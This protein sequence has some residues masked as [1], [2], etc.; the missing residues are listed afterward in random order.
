METKINEFLE[1]IH[2]KVIKNRKYYTFGY[3][4]EYHKKANYDYGYI[5][6]VTGLDFFEKE[7]IIPKTNPCNRCGVLK[8]YTEFIVVHDTASGAPSANG[9]AHANWINSMANDVNSK[10]TVSWHFTVDEDGIYQHLPI[11]EVG[12]HAGDG[13]SVKLTYTDTL[14]KADK[15]ECI[16]SIDEDGFFVLNGIKSSIEAPKTV[17]NEVVKNNQLPYQGINVKIGNNGTYLLGNTYWNNSYEVLANKGGNLNSVGIETCVNYGAD[18]IKTMR[19]TAYLVAKLL[20]N[21]NLDI[22][23]V[24]QHNFFSGKDCP[25]TIRHANM[26]EEF[27]ELVKIN[28]IYLKEF[29]DYKIVFE[30]LSPENLDNEG[31]IIKHQD[32]L[33]VRYK[34]IFSKDNYKKEY[35]FESKLDKLS[36]EIE[37]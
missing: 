23:Q 11:D 7:E 26:W 16:V 28:L 34:V 35:I 17:N 12:Y 21:Y 24:K 5:P 9:R 25:M 36:F 22:T 37:E 32:N 1:L 27:L 19:I 29:K 18:Y 20:I 4:K 30:S 31:K 33:I 15:K 3:Q 2:K 6:F 14:I 13:T 10:T 8:E